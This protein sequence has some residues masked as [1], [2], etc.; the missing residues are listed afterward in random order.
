MKLICKGKLLKDE[1]SLFQQEVSNGAQVM[2]LMLTGSPEET[3]AFE[4][5]KK[6]LDNTKR[7]VE[8]IA[9]GEERA[10]GSYL[11]VCSKFYQWQPN[12]YGNTTLTGHPTP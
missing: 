6:S 1:E 11:E 3:A 8:M 7:D 9:K 12:A 2:C 4:K 5:R 10:A